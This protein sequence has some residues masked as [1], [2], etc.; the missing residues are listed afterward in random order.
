MDNNTRR[1]RYNHEVQVY[2][3]NRVS[4]MDEEKVPSQLLNDISEESRTQGV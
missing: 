1:T 2:F 3:G 4:R